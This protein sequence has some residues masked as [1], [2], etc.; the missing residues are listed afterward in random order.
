MTKFVPRACLDGGATDSALTK[1][2]VV[3]VV[4]SAVE[5]SPAGNQKQDRIED[6]QEE[7]K[8]YVILA[9]RSLIQPEEAVLQPRARTSFLSK[10]TAGL[11]DPGFESIVKPSSTVSTS[12]TKPSLSDELALPGWPAQLKRKRNERFRGQPIQQSEQIEQLAWPS[13]F[14]KQRS[15]RSQTLPLSMLSWQSTFKRTRS[16]RSLQPADQPSTPP[17]LSEQLAS[18]SHRSPASSVPRRRAQTSRDSMLHRLISSFGKYRAR[19][20]FL[21]E[22]L[23]EKT[24]RL[25]LQNWE[26]HRRRAMREIGELGIPNLFSR[27]EWLDAHVKRP[28]GPPRTRLDEAGDKMRQAQ[29]RLR[30]LRE[31][32]AAEMGKVNRKPRV[33]TFAAMKDPRKPAALQDHS[34]VESALLPSSDSDLHPGRT[35]TAR[36]GMRADGQSAT[37]SKGPAG[38][39]S[40]QALPSVAASKG[41]QPLQVY[42]FEL[43]NN[44]SIPPPDLK[45]W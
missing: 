25:K 35:S 2:A 26:S 41:Y 37:A 22:G 43:S 42:P 5:R 18:S 20:S 30:Q 7:E 12:N 27:E 17:I 9:N 29:R 39:A 21:D 1:S 32:E 15:E 45:W 44:L 33:S 4:P 14:K 28:S 38:S 11:D 24:V 13:G 23:D 6:D 40:R 36:K 34:D 10:I 31:A 8:P 16:S 3:E 19:P